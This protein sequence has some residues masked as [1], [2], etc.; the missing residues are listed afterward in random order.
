MHLTGYEVAGCRAALGAMSAA[1]RAERVLLDVGISA[2]VVALER[3]ETKRGCAF[4]PE[5]EGDEAT[6]HQPN[7][8]ITID[9]LETLLKIYYEGIK[10]LCQ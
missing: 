3:A 1:I 2:Q 8:Y 9:R 7:E 10:E 4:G 5:M 6:I